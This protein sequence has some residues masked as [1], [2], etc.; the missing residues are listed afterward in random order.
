MLWQEATGGEEATGEF[1]AWVIIIG[2]SRCARS[3]LIRQSFKIYQSCHQQSNVCFQKFTAPPVTKIK[4]ISCRNMCKSSLLFDLPT[5]LPTWSLHMF[6]YQARD[7]SHWQRLT[8]YLQ[9]WQDTFFFP[10]PVSNSLS[11]LYWQFLYLPY[12][13]CKNGM[14]IVYG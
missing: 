14:V 5:K 8:H 12:I 13:I 3:L 11:L 10:L 6:K 2:D 7:P 9:L 1:V 4:K